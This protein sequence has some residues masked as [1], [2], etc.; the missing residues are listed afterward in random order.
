MGLSG[1]Q[2]FKMLP[3]TNCGDCGVPTCLA[4]AMNL[5]SGKAELDS[6]PHVSDEAREQLESSSAPPIRTVKWGEGDNQV[7]VGGETVSYRHEKTFFNPPGLAVLVADDEDVDSVKGKLDRLM[8]LQF[9]RVGVNLRGEC[10][11]LKSN[12]GDAGKMKALATLVKENSDA[13]P[14]LMGEPDVIEAGLE[15]LKDRKPVLY[16]AHR[17]NAQAMA[18]LAQKYAAPLAVVGKS[19]DEVA[20]LTQKLTDAGLKDLVIDSGCRSIKQAL[21]DQV[22]MRRLATQQTFR[23]LGFPSIV[24]PCEM[25]DDFMMEN[26]YASLFIAKYAGIVVM[27]DL[28]GENL[29]PLTVERLNIYTDPQRPMKTTE[30]IYEI[31]NPT[32]QSPVLITSNFSLTYFVVSGEIEASRVPTWLLVLDTDGLSVLTAWAA[33]KFVGD[34]V[35]ALVKKCG[36]ADKVSAKK[37]VLPG[38][39]AVLTGDVEEELP[40][41]EVIVGPR[42]SAHI[43]AF[44]KQNYA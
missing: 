20:D 40:D 11:A 5:A 10:V 35:G 36:I 9:E 12:T 32:E 8:K 30:G 25:T 15:V 24:F 4:F 16:A 38:Y 3:K 13:A 23:P 21:F 29:Y 1:I 28:R 19:L 31:N 27:S 18:T 7:A 6:C 33:G 39:V 34:T 42:E 14:I 22:T 41:W 37:L 26:I 43:P 44:L 2:I 17:G